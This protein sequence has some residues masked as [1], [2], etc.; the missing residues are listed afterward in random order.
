MTDGEGAWHDITIRGRKLAAVIKKCNTQF[1]HLLEK[2]D[3][4]TALAFL[5]RLIKAEN[6]IRPYVETY[7]GVTRFM[8][9]KRKLENTIQIPAG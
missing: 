6:A 9:K 2:E 4:D 8:S 7:N 5:D 1:Y 3:Y